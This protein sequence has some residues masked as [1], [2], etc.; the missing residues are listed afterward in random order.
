MFVDHPV[1]PAIKADFEETFPR[2]ETVTVKKHRA[3][4]F[5]DLYLGLLRLFAPLM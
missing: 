4:F 3:S 2:C 5:Y 1:L